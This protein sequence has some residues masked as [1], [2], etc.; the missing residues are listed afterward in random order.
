M[1]VDD[2]AG[3]RQPEAEALEA[4]GHRIGALREGLEAAREALR[5]DALAAVSDRGAG[6]SAV[7]GDGHLDAA[8]A[9]RM[10]DGVGEQLLQ[11]GA[12]VAQVAGRVLPA[13]PRVSTASVT[14]AA[15]AGPRI[16]RT[17]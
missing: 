2:A 10:G 9:G 11:R 4:A 6:E 7:A 8:A 13:R 16:A 15:V 14:F 1:Q 12:E 17:A 5:R 3:E